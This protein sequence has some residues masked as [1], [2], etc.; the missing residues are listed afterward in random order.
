MPTS[1][2]PCAKPGVAELF[3]TFNRVYHNEVSIE[4]ERMFGPCEANGSTCLSRLFL[5]R[6]FRRAPLCRALLFR[7]GRHRR[8][9]GGSSEPDA[10]RYFPY[11]GDASDRESPA[12]CVFQ[13]LRVGG[14]A[15]TSPRDATQPWPPPFAEAFFE[16]GVANFICT[17]WPVD[18][19][20]APGFRVPPLRWPAWS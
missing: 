17:A 20:A 1:R 6:T 18:D 2:G 5:D 3:Q 8:P 13:R 15:R 19:V 4:V 16:R 7:R 12:F 10:A 11:T 14:N 9:R